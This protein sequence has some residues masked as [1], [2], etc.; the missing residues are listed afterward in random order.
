MWQTDIIAH[1]KKFFS[2]SYCS[3]TQKRAYNIHTNH[4]DIRL[5]DMV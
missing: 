1:R 5:E 2:P 3:D 4:I